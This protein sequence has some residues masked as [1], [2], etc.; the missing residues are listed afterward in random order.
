MDGSIKYDPRRF[1]GC[2]RWLVCNDRAASDFPRHQPEPI[3]SGRL[4]LLAVAAYGLFARS[5]RIG[6]GSW[7]HG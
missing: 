6:N 2:T 5:C 1:Y 3:S 4:N 7:P